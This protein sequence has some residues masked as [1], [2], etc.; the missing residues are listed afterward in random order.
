MTDLEPITTPEQYEAAREMALKYEERGI[1]MQAS[2]DRKIAELEIERAEK[3]ARPTEILNN[4]RSQLWALEAQCHDYELNEAKVSEQ[5][6]EPKGSWTAEVISLSDL[7]AAAALNFEYM[8]YLQPN[9]VALNKVARKL[10]RTM[11]V[12]GVVA[13]RKEKS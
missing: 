10:K 2:I 11:Y 4:L 13:T 7:I 6:E 8:Q 1:E 9:Q 12:P 5:M 3:L